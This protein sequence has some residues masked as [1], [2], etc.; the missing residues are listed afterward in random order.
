M[1]NNINI[2]YVLNEENVYMLFISMYSVIFNNQQNYLTFY[3]VI[4]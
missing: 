2:V 1:S 4:D 3:L